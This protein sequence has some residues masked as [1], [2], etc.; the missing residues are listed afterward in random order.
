MTDKRPDP[1]HLLSQVQSQE[2]RN[3]AGQ[4]RIFLGYAA[5]VG[6]TYAMLQSAR[7]AR[8]GG[9]DIVIGY[10]EPHARP[11]T[12][13]LIDGFETLEPLSVHH[14]GLKVRE[15]DVDAAIR[16]KPELLLVDELAHSNAEG[17]R[18]AKRWQDIE[19]LL[20][21]GIDVWT[22]LNVQHIES[23]NDVIAQVTGVTVRETIPDSVF[24]SADEIELIDIA[25]EDLIHR[26][27]QG[28]VYSGEQ[29]IVALQSF[30][31]RSNLHA[32]RELSLRQAA[33]RIHSDVEDSRRLLQA[34]APWVTAERFM[35]CVGPSP[36]TAKVIRA[37]KRMSDA[38]DAPWIAVS[39]E[40]SNNSLKSQAV[41]MIVDHFRL[42]E[43]LGADTVTL[44]G[45][46][47]P[48][49]LIEYARD[50]NITR[51]LVGKTTEPKWRR[52]L[53]GNLVDR[54][55]DLS[56]EI[57]VLVVQGASDKQP[58]P[59]DRSH[60]SWN[61]RNLLWAGLILAFCTSLAAL[62]HGLR[63]ADSEAN[64]VMIFLAGVAF[65]GYL[66]G[67]GVSSFACV[68]AVLT[69]DF[70]FVPP[71]MTLAVADTQYLVTFLIM[72]TIGVGISN[73]TAR[74]R[75]QVL[76]V[77]EREQR[78]SSLYALGKQLSSLSGQVFL[79]NAAASKIAALTGADVMIFLVDETGK[80][81]AT[82][83]PK[84]SI[85]DAPTC[86][87]A[88]KWVVQHGQ[89]A[90]AGTN[91]LPAT[92]SLY[93]PLIGTQ[94]CL[95]TIAIASQSKSLFSPEYRHFLEACASQ[96]ALAIERDVSVMAASEA[97]IETETEQ[98]RSSLLSSVS[99]DLRT[100]L[101]TIGGASQSLLECHSLGLPL[102]RDLLQSIT[103]E[104]ARLMRLLENILQMSK[105]EAGQS[106][107]KK[108]WHVVEE[109]ISVSLK[110]T[111]HALER[112]VVTVAIP[113]DLRLICV[114]GLLIEQL[115]V[116]VLENAAI[117]TPPGTQV[118]IWAVEEPNTLALHV[119]DSGPGI[120][121]ALA[122]KIFHKFVRATASPDSVRG[123]GLG[124]A[125]A[126]SI[127]RCHGGDIVIQKSELGGADF[128]LRLPLDGFAPRMPMAN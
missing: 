54:L 56:G 111:Q 95:G 27:E 24:Q 116:N 74:L 58:Q 63:L 97:R 120:L 86:L 122:E 38:I 52:W 61:L 115:L 7:R 19:E 6:K 40:T 123:S 53:R 39:V 90:G 68:L 128:V 78:M 99:H 71:Y 50:H 2:K 93:L 23:L 44:Y 49:T 11:E 22:T 28:K 107:P 117:H 62:L 80:V 106:T 103:D 101:A 83:T 30:F 51:I 79:C 110:R 26:L 125:I 3:Q 34:R 73:L 94:R 121:A 32:L 21:Q 124:L 42:A 4:L 119:S 64:T 15:F 33:H 31:Q 88:A 96:L 91:T 14:H 65:I 43:S 81:E 36:T 66:F 92:P 9:T 35:V 98:L 82:T 70:F 126:R 37:A 13:A 75:R 113:S 85:A 8:I 89:V 59:I 84:S 67:R 17:C 57:D 10:I 104:S 25:P 108:D 46:D 69:F 60:S 76:V 18:H 87:A 118:R 127:A 100:P 16:R 20:G 114:D 1:D 55:V 72:L 102:Q 45:D 77:Q 105:L 47:V 112:H 48:R 12:S 41:G 109:L 29:A 5:G